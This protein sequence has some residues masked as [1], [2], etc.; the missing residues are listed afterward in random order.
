LT[1]RAASDGSPYPQSA[2]AGTPY[3]SDR[4]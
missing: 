3:L 4:C 2:A 1:R